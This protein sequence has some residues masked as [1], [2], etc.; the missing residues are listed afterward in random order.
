[1]LDQTPCRH[2]YSVE[3][4]SGVRDLLSLIG[5][6]TPEFH[7]PLFYWEHPMSGEAVLAVGAAHAI[8]TS[9]TDRIGKA[10]RAALDVLARSTPREPSSCDDAPRPRFVGGFAFGSDDPVSPL[11]R[12]FPSCWLFLPE[13]MWLLKD[14][15]CWSIRVSSCGHPSAHRQGAPPVLGMD[16]RSRPGV[17]AME[18]PDDQQHWLSRVERALSMVEEGA[19]TKV[20]L[21]RHRTWTAVREI[22]ALSIA[23]QLRDSRP[24][25]FTFCVSPG[26]SHFF[27]STPELLLRLHNGRFETQAL[28]GTAPRDRNARRDRKSASRLLR[29]AKN[30]REHAAVVLGIEQALG[31][32]AGPFRVAPQPDLIALPEAYHLRTAIAGHV[33][34]SI[35]SL[36]LAD[37][38]HPTAAVCGVPRHRARSLIETEE[39]DRG[40]YTGAVGW[41]DGSGDGVFAVALRAALARD[42]QFTVWAGAGI[43]SGS[44][45]VAE[46]EETEIKMRAMVDAVRNRGSAGM[47]A[48]VIAPPRLAE[49]GG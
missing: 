39:P 16:E 34:S 8:R 19:L 21:A 15:R 46:F 18:E 37:L 49:L 2:T 29:S 31:A 27:G 23:R 13:Q 3:R 22:S 14:G 32:V 30:L 9:G 10:G 40:W 36:D 7:V 6:G 1:M 42:R 24:G 17:P 45:P 35:N 4:V 33:R 11:W 47:D 48:P 12:E 25:C 26:R 28:A 44:D 43:V 20:V 41:M 38:L 5:Q